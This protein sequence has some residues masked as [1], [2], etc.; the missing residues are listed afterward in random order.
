M[1]PQELYLP[2]SLSRLSPPHSYP[3]HL[4]AYAGVHVYAGAASGGSCPFIGI[5][6]QHCHEPSLAAA[7]WLQWA[8]CWSAESGPTSSWSQPTLLCIPSY[9]TKRYQGCNCHQPYFQFD[10]QKAVN[11]QPYAI[12]ALANTAAFCHATQKHTLK[13]FMYIVC[14]YSAK[15]VVTLLKQPSKPSPSFLLMPVMDTILY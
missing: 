10:M 8:T 11:Q 3:Q 7:L 15:T 12:L 4:W 9:L 1:H 2:P 14:I 6:H 5:S 13:G